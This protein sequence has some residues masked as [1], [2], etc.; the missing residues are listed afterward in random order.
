ML[1]KDLKCKTNL[2]TRGR[3]VEFA[4]EYVKTHT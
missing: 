3:E 4:Y 1:I 2:I